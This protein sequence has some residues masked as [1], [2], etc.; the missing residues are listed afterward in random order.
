MS[1]LFEQL[2]ETVRRTPRRPA[3]VTGGGAVSYERLA[4][5]SHRIA[6]ALRADGLAAN[7]RVA[8]LLENSA[9]FVLAYL[10]ILRAGGVVVPCNPAAPGGSTRL[11]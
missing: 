2:E 3:L 5:A 9:E 1:G 11:P 10:G 7:D 4:G 8:L 6:C